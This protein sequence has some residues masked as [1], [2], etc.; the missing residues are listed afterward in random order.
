MG[1]MTVPY[2]S[3]CTK[4]GD[5]FV[6]FG[7]AGVC[8][9]FAWKQRKGGGCHLLMIEVKAGRDVVSMKQ[10]SWLEDARNHG[11]HA[12]IARSCE[13]VEAIAKGLL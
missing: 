5:R 13:D 6:K 2:R 10:E 9:L 1:W 8:D 4:I 7:D 11:A 12:I 3:G